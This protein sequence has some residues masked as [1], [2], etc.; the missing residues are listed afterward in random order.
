[1]TDCLW[2]RLPAVCEKAAIDMELSVSIVGLSYALT[3][4]VFLA[5][6]FF[7]LGWGAKEL[8]QR[9]IGSLLKDHVNWPAAAMFYLIYI[10]GIQ[11]FVILPA[12]MTEHGLGVAAIRGGLLGFFAYSTFDLTCLALVRGWSA[13]VA[14][15]DIIWGTLLTGSTVAATLLIMDYLPIT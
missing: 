7:W 11:V 14:L 1:M 3:A 13:T 9:H 6:D 15:V 2:L 5:L 4:G 10:G 12:L 8:Y